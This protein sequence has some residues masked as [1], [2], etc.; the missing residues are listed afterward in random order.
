MVM[1]RDY[2]DND[3][4]R[5]VGVSRVRLW[6]GL[7]LCCCHCINWSGLPGRDGVDVEGLFVVRI[8]GGCERGRKRVSG[9]IDRL[10]A[11]S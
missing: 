1:F 3:A 8:S 7:G 4:I 6:I 2:G 5:M 9:E 10:Y 11:G